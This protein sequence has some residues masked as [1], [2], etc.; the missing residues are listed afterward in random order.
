[1][2]LKS[3]YSGSSHTRPDSS[4][5]IWTIIEKARDQRLNEYIPGRKG[6]NVLDAFKKGDKY[7]RGSTLESF[8]Q[9]IV[10]KA[11]RYRDP[12]DAPALGEGVD[13]EEMDEIPPI[14]IVL[15]PDA[16]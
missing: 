13:E 10:L 6:A 1:M 5:Y 7:V 16:E 12:N 14:D 15:N 2:E 9:K 4:S 8:N 11:A 3:R